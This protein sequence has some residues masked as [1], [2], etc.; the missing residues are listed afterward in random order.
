MS[1]AL[2]H[3]TALSLVSGELKIGSVGSYRASGKRELK[4]YLASEYK[5]ETVRTISM[6]WRR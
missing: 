5:K 1:L 3:K 2:K 4:K 6:S